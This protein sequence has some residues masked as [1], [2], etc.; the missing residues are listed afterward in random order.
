[1]SATLVVP[2]LSDRTR[3]LLWGALGVLAFSVSLPATR[4]ALL[5]GMSPAFVSFGRAGVAGVLSLVVLVAWRQRWPGWRVVGR[6]LSTSA[7]IVFGFPLFIGFAL[8]RVPAAHGIVV[9]GLLPAMTAVFAVVRGGE[10]P[11]V[12]FWLAALA[13]LGCVMAFA[14]VAGGGVVAPADL[15]LLGAVVTGAWGYAEG[16]VLSRTL[17]AVR[18]ICL[19]LVASVPLTVPLMAWAAT[20]VDWGA[21]T[22]AAWLGFSY[23][24][25]VSMFAG[26]FAWYHGLA[27]GGVARVGQVQL[28]QPLLSLLWAGLLLGERITAAMFAVAV[29]VILCVAVAQRSR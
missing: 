27:L 19:V 28:L 2:G 24:S 3:G 11:S 15:L 5:G 16:A 1:M 12:L 7:G 13:G 18:V 21:V 4:V 26:F 29:A 14:W 20:S 17:G 25:L 6:L 22:P 23:L 8:K 10:R 9:T